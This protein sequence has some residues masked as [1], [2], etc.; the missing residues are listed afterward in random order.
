MID[1]IAIS[2]GKREPSLVFGVQAFF[3][4]FNSALQALIFGVVHIL[5]GFIEGQPN[6][7]YLKNA[8]WMETGSWEAWK[9]AVFGIQIHSI[10][11]PFIIMTI[12]TI[13]FAIL[14]RLTP[15]RVEEN[16]KKLDEMNVI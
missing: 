2:S 7:V 13:L 14:Y 1:D 15:E 9:L 6:L 8:I 5:T 11:I 10:I 4:R 16:R 12:S 3:V